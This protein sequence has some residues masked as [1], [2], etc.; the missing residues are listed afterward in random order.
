MP[1]GDGGGGVGVGHVTGSRG[2]V[3]LENRKKKTL[4]SVRAFVLR[5]WDFLEIISLVAKE[6]WNYLGHELRTWHYL[7]RKL[8]RGKEHTF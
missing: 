3:C 5:A 1:A 7:P 6:Q 2:C 4:S 8:P